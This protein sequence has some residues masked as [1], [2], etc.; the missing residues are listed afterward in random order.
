MKGLTTVKRSHSGSSHPREKLI[1]FLSPR[2]TGLLCKVLPKRV[3][4]DCFPLKL[5]E[6]ALPR[7]AKNEIEPRPV[8]MSRVSQVQRVPGTATLN[9][10]GTGGGG[11]GGGGGDGGG[12]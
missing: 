7:K 3:H 12:G 8:L 6:G 9:A 4:L 10:P 1:R 11:G 2:G 5:L